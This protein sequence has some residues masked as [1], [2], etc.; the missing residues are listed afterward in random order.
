MKEADDLDA[1][2]WRGRVDDP[3]LLMHH[4]ALCAMTGRKRA[5]MALLDALCAP[6]LAPRVAQVKPQPVL[7]QTTGFNAA[8]PH[9]QPCAVGMVD[10]QWA[11]ATALAFDKEY[12]S[13]QVIAAHF[14]KLTVCDPQTWKVNADEY[15]NRRR[16]HWG[17]DDETLLQKAIQAWR[18][19]GPLAGEGEHDLARLLALAGGLARHEQAM[20]GFQR[21]GVDLEAFTQWRV[22]SANKVVV[23]G[24]T[25][26]PAKEPAFSMPVAMLQ[27]YNIAGATAFLSCLQSPMAR[28]L[29]QQIA[30]D[31]CGCYHNALAW[32]EVCEAQVDE[33]FEGPVTS[34]RE[35]TLALLD[36]I[37]RL[38]PGAAADGVRMSMLRV[39][40]DGLDRHGRRVD[41]E[42]VAPW[43]ARPG[44]GAGECLGQR[45]S[46]AATALAE[47]RIPD[48][49]DGRALKVS[50]CELVKGSLKAHCVQVLD[51]VRPVLLQV[52]AQESMAD[53]GLCRD[54]VIKLVGGLDDHKTFVEA[55]FR[56]TL[57]LL[58][59]C[60]LSLDAVVPLNSSVT[61]AKVQRTTSMLHELAK[62][63]NPS[64]CAALA[65]ALEMGIDPDVRNHQRWTAAALITDSRRR[66]AWLDVQ[67][68]HQARSV[69][70]AAL[71]QD[72]DCLA[73][74]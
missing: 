3:V 50:L 31:L 59:D 53:G 6:D 36:Q 18:P 48:D 60:G 64:Q 29:A 44:G 38:Y 5:L 58:K 66:A 62:S 14:N 23:R 55:N 34:G 1:G 49:M 21:A 15:V 72:I 17:S 40:L 7:V 74:R 69:A 8:P 43:L 47:D 10:L 63:N 9:M 19:G 52:A 73:P 46:T 45:I 57:Q 12:Q 25:E 42:V 37:D 22:S 70:H 51:L 61:T 30:I 71:A 11:V 4:A 54:E 33:A 20:L 28:S 16:T 68:S 39:I 26:P 56:K 2:V 35:E 65:V 27:Q 32:H 13:Q 41:E 24:P 67:R